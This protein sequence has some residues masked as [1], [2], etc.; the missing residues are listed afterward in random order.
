MDAGACAFVAE[1]GLHGQARQERPQ[2]AEDVL[3]SGGQVMGI[4]RQDIGDFVEKTSMVV[5]KVEYHIHG[6]V[7]HDA[8]S[9]LAPARKRASRADWPSSS[10]LYDYLTALDRRR[11]LTSL[12]SLPLSNLQPAEGWRA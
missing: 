3:A 4:A 10:S 1:V 9:I 12:S 8:P 7:D 5:D 11:R 2:H 6:P